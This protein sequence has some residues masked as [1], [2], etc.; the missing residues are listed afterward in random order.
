[1]AG[2]NIIFNKVLLKVFIEFVTGLLLLYVL[3][4]WP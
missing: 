4:L 3:V 2:I 1:M